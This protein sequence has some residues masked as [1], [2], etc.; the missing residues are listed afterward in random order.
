[1]LRKF[2]WLV[3]SSIILFSCARVE[4]YYYFSGVGN[5]EFQPA[6]ADSAALKAIIQP[7]D[8]L[9]IL[10]SSSSPELTLLFNSSNAGGATMAGATGGSSGNIVLG[11]LVDSNGDIAFPQLGNVRVVGLSTVEI[12]EMLEKGLIP[13]LKNVVVNT[14]VVNFRISVL[15]EVA[16]PGMYNVP[17]DRINV[18]QGLA[19]AGDLT[20]FGQREN[21]LLIREVQGKRTTHRLNLNDRSILTD[22]NYYLKNGDI[23]YVEPNRTRVNQSSTFFQV[24]PTVTSAVTLLILVLNNLQN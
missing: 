16:R 4:D 24:W 10:V 14:R 5:E 18:I 11:Y 12:Q 15:G 9:S 22:P 1:M 20:I 13:L 8:Q 2:G 7:G 3:V 23:L 21:V 19:F 17:Y 6:A